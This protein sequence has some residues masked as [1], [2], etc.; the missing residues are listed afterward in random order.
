M[1]RELWRERELY[2]LMVENA[3]DIV[4]QLRADGMIDWVSPSVQRI[5]GYAASTL[6]GTAPWDLVHP[7]DVEDAAVAVAAAMSTDEQ[8]PAV[9]VRIRRSDGVHV[10]M[11][12][13]ARRAE[14]N[15]LVVSF[16]QA[17]EAMRERR[18]REAS[19]RALARPFRQAG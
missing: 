19:C 3:S 14:D 9:E 11:S 13:L 10:W 16:R 4:V 12:A 15:H 2:R 17:E 8:V 18:A 5:L 6:I 1:S 7:D